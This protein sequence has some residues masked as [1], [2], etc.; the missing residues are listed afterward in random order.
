MRS[1]EDS[2]LKE[3]AEAD[4]LTVAGMVPDDGVIFSLDLNGKP[5][6]DIPVESVSLQAVYSILDAVL[7]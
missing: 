1:T 6:F 3:V 5:V 4:G 2:A 7:A